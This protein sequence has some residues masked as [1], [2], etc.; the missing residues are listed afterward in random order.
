MAASLRTAID[1]AR[2]SAVPSSLSMPRARVVGALARVEARKMLRHPAFLLTIA[3]GLLL[4]RGSVGLRAGEGGLII[5]LVWLVAHTT[6]KPK[7]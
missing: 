1:G 2:A 6:V 4:L 3:F 7:T 5:N